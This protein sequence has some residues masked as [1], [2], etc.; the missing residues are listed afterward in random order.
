VEGRPIK[1]DGNPRH[2]ASLGA[3][4]V[5]AEAELLSLYDPD[6][7]K[8]PRNCT[9]IA[10]WSAFV[11]A[12]YINAVP[13]R[14]MP[15]PETFPAPRLEVDEHAQLQRILEA[16]RQC[17]DQYRWTDESH[18]YAQIPIDRAMAII[19]REGAQAYAPLIASEPALTSPTAGAERAI[20]PDGKSTPAPVTAGRPPSEGIGGA[21]PAI[22]DP[23]RALQEDRK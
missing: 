6:R 22:S 2:P 19:A 8:A 13:V 11:G 9:T 4:D 17:L 20:T 21:S 5:F 14:T 10:S 15:A 7:S 3:T 18:K 16:Q 12:L 1:I 23:Q